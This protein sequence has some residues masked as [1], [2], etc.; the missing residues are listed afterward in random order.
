MVG[1]R[2]RPKAPAGRY[3]L[4]NGIEI[5]HQP[6]GFFSLFNEIKTF[7]ICFKF[8]NVFV[9]KFKM[10]LPANGIEIFAT[11]LLDFSLSFSMDLKHFVFVFK[12]KS[13]FVSMFKIYLP[14]NGIEIFY[15]TLW[16]FCLTFSLKLNIKISCQRFEF[17]SLFF[18]E[19]FSQ[20]DKECCI[21]S[22]SEINRSGWGWSG[23]WTKV[24]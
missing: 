14:G 22:N 10:Y 23:W 17:V 16:I 4:A 6:S 5:S 9:L 21:K 8:K 18:T 2:I 11:N 7:C 12:L 13:A 24:F 19:M 1:N 20:W 15:W 3:L